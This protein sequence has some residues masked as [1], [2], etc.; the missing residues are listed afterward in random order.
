LRKQVQ[1]Y[2][3]LVHIKEEELTE[4]KNSSKFS[5]FHELDLKLAN[6][7]EELNQL[8]EKY[9]QLRS[10]ILEYFLLNF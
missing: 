3:T 1:D 5:K 7:V 2:K 10:S 9:T 4:I 8:A 6:T